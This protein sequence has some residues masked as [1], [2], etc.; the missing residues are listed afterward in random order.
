MDEKKYVPSGCQLLC[1]KGVT[2]TPLNVTS[3]K[4]TIYGDNFATEV[5]LKPL[6]NIKP[7]GAC[8]LKSGSPCTFAPIYWDKCVNGAKVNG[9]KLIIGEAKLLCTQGG[10]ISIFY[11]KADAMAAANENAA[12][13]SLLDRLLGL[14]NL[15]GGYGMDNASTFLTDRFSALSSATKGIDP[16]ALPNT[17][18][19]GNFG[20]LR[21]QL[22]L[23]MKGY[24]TISNSQATSVQGGGHRG[25]D[26]AATDPRGSVDVLAES[27]YSSTGNKPKMG[28]APKSGGTQMGDNW[29][30]NRRANRLGNSMSAADAARIRGSI[31]SGSP[32]LL[33][34]ASQVSPQGGVSYYNIDA[35]GKVGNAVDLPAANVIGGNSRAANTINSISRNIQSNRGIATA[36]RFMVN[37]SA[38][39]GKVGRVAGRGFIVVGVVSEGINI[40]NAYK[41]DGGEFGENTKKAVGSA[42]G[43][44]AGGI[45]GAQIGATI[46]AVGGP[47]GVVVGGVAGGIIGGI[48]GSSAGKKIAG[49]F[50]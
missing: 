50:S 41:Q 35:A 4:S 18:Q 44:L 11:S 2:P 45:A 8:S 40:G 34:V 39:I 47:V 20:E 31:R 6:E 13:K 46:G 16:T 23:E 17:T 1:N 36:N 29:L 28:N 42:A 22:D 15:G 3:N 24:N 49:W 27:K 48:A 30:L 7:F 25:L 10:E 12:E 33:R 43:G 26:L 14:P 38:A 5:D 21:T 32:N 19:Q 37:N 9:N